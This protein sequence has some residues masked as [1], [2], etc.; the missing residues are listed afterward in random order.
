MGEFFWEILE[1]IIGKILS[2][3]GLSL[4]IKHLHQR[5][6]QQDINYYNAPRNKVPKTDFFCKPRS[7]LHDECSNQWSFR[8]R[9][10]YHH[11][12]ITHLL[13]PM[14]PWKHKAIRRHFTKLVF[15][16]IFSL[17]LLCF[18]Y[19][20]IFK[21]MC[22]MNSLGPFHKSYWLNLGIYFETNVIQNYVIFKQF[23]K[24][25]SVVSKII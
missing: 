5:A 1:T 18:I 3:I 9:C 14:L 24:N 12:S 8:C 15:T 16:L 20:R 19:I 25:T 7:Y 6:L 21:T 17:L 2:I 22:H 11:K 4:I 13:H 23:H 10:T